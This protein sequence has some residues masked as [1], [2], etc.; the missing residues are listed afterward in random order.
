MAQ[1]WMGALTQGPEMAR[2]FTAKS[3]G[4]TPEYEDLPPLEEG[5]A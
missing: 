5:A 4:A 1:L 2:Y 3:E